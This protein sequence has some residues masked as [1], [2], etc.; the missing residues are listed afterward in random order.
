MG[1]DPAGLLV[2]IDEALQFYLR[3]EDLFF[4][5]R[6]FKKSSL[7]LAPAALSLTER[8]RIKIKIR[9]KINRVFR[10]TVRFIRIAFVF[11]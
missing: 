3:T 2:V 7:S 5:K 9:I 10:I 1:I 11:F 6:I 8:F 4:K